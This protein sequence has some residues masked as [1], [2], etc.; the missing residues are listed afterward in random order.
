VQAA[1]V[2]HTLARHLNAPLLRAGY[3]PAQTPTIEAA[4][5]FL[6]RAGDQVLSQLFSFEH[7]GQRLALRPEFTT[8]ALQHYIEAGTAGQPLGLVRWSFEGV[9]Y[10]EME[11]DREAEH[12]TVGAELIGTAAPWA[13]GEAIAVAF[14]GVQHALNAQTDAGRVV[15]VG[16]IGLVRAALGALGFDAREQ[17]LLLHGRADPPAAAGEATAASAIPTATVTADTLRS[18]L[19]G[20]QRQNTMGGRTADEIAE[21]LARKQARRTQAARWETGRQLMQDLARTHTLAGL[22]ERLHTLT[23]AHSAVGE[24]L[25]NLEHVLAWAAALGVPDAIVQIQPMIA[26]AWEYYT[27][28]VFQIEYDGRVLTSGGR[29]D[30]LARLL[31]A[32]ADIPAVGFVH[33]GDAFPQP[34]YADSGDMP[35]CTLRAAADADPAAAGRWLHALRAAVPVV[36]MPAAEQYDGPDASFSITLTAEGA[37][38][39]RGAVYTQA[40]ALLAALLAALRAA[41]EIAPVTTRPE[42][43]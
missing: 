2:R 40:D 38:V 23:A 28:V 21:R 11:R 24:A 37:A 34:A 18:V 25:A 12:F 26:R 10:E 43:R 4:D 3:Q 42:D 5:I 30:E 35:T 1:R 22:R 31:G 7:R 17:N 13:D 39:W 36:L 33:Y 6:T 19:I 14:A 41:S 27:G 9:V 16:H 15:R 29:Y 20:G 8:P 32:R